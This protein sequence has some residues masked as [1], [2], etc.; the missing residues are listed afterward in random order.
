[1]DQDSS[2][3]TVDIE[4]QIQSCH[5]KLQELERHRA[6][7]KAA[8]AQARGEGPSSSTG[9]WHNPSG[10]P[11]NFQTPT[12]IP[13]EF[14]PLYEYYRRNVANKAELI[15]SKTADEWANRWIECW[16]KLGYTYKGLMSMV[17]KHDKSVAEKSADP[18]ELPKKLWELLNKNRSRLPRISSV[19]FIADRTVEHFMTE[20]KR[21]KSHQEDMEMYL[22]AKSEAQ[23]S[24][25]TTTP[26]P[27]KK[28][29][30]EETFIA[31]NKELYVF[32][33]NRIEAMVGAQDKQNALEVVINVVTVEA[34]LNGV[35]VLALYCCDDSYKQA[36]KP[37]KIYDLLELFLQSLDLRELQKFMSKEHLISMLIEYC[38]QSKFVTDKMFRTAQAFDAYNTALNSLPVTEPGPQFIQQLPSVISSQSSLLNPPPAPE[39]QSIPAQYLSDPAEI[40]TGDENEEKPRTPSPTLRVCDPRNFSFKHGYDPK[41]FEKVNHPFKKLSLVDFK[42]DNYLRVYVHIE[43]LGN[44]YRESDVI[45][46]GAYTVCGKKFFSAILPPQE[47][48]FE[49]LERLGYVTTGRHG[50][51]LRDEDIYYMHEKDKKVPHDTPMEG[52][53]EFGKF[54]KK[55]SHREGKDGV[56][57]M[58]LHSE[59]V[60]H[61]MKD[62]HG[63]FRRK[64]RPDRWFSSVVG[65]C[66]LEDFI[67]W[68]LLTK[69]EK[70]YRITVQQAYQMITGQDS[71]EYINEADF[72]AKLLCTIGERLWEQTELKTTVFNFE[73]DTDMQHFDDF[74][75]GLRRLADI[76]DVI[77][78]SLRRYPPGDS[79]MNGV[80]NLFP[81]SLHRREVFER[82]VPKD[83]IVANKY[84]EI[85]VSCGLTWTV[86]KKIEGDHDLNTLFSMIKQD[87]IDDE[88]S[89]G[90]TSLIESCIATTIDVLIRHRKTSKRPHTPESRQQKRVEDPLP[91]HKRLR[92]ESPQAVPSPPSRPPST[93]PS[94]SRPG[95]YTPTEY[96]RP[97]E[98]P[99]PDP[100]RQKLHQELSQELSKPKIQKDY[101]PL[102]DHLSDL[103]SQKPNMGSRNSQVLAEEMV[104][105]WQRISSFKELQERILTDQDSAV[106][107]AQ[108]KFH[109]SKN[110]SSNPASWC[111]FSLDFLIKTTMDFIKSLSKRAS[112]VRRPITDPQPKSGTQRKERKNEEK[113]LDAAELGFQNIRRTIP[114]DDLKI[115][116][117]VSDEFK[118]VL[119]SLETECDGIKG[120]YPMWKEM[121]SKLILLDF[122]KLLSRNNLTVS[123]LCSRLKK[124]DQPRRICSDLFGPTQRKSKGYQGTSDFDIYRQLFSRLADELLGKNTGKP[125]KTNPPKEHK[126][127]KTQK[128]KKNKSDAEESDDLSKDEN[129]VKMEPLTEE[130][131]KE[132]LDEFLSSKYEDYLKNRRCPK[133]E[134]LELHE[135]MSFSPMMKSGKNHAGHDRWRVVNDIIENMVS[136]KLNHQTILDK[137]KQLD[138]DTSV[139]Q[140]VENILNMDEPQLLPKSCTE[141]TGTILNCVT[142]FYEQ[143]R[144]KVRLSQK[145]LEM[146]CVRDENNGLHEL[147]EYIFRCFASE[148][149]FMI[150]QGEVVNLTLDQVN[151]DFLHSFAQDLTRFLININFTIYESVCHFNDGVLTNVLKFELKSRQNDIP[152]NFKSEALCRLC[153]D[154][155][156]SVVRRK[157]P[158][159]LPT[160]MTI[161]KIIKRKLYVFIKAE[162]IVEESEKIEFKLSVPVVVDEEIVDRKVKKNN[163][164]SSWHLTSKNQQLPIKESLASVPMYKPDEKDSLT[165]T[166]TDEDFGIKSETEATFGAEPFIDTVGSVVTTW[167]VRLPPN[168]ARVVKLALCGAPRIR[169]LAPLVL[170]SSEEFVKTGCKLMVKDAALVASNSVVVTIVNPN[171]TDAVKFKGRTRIGFCKVK[172]RSDVLMEVDPALYRLQFIKQ[173]FVMN[174]TEG[175]INDGS[176]IQFTNHFNTSFEK[177]TKVALKSVGESETQYSIDTLLFFMQHF[178]LKIHYTDYMQLAVAHG[179]DLVNK[180]HSRNIY[181]YLT[182][183]DSLRNELKVSTNEFV[184]HCV[185]VTDPELILQYKDYPLILQELTKY[186]D[187]IAK[188]TDT[189]QIRQS[190]EIAEAKR[191]LEKF[192]ASLQESN[193]RLENLQ[194]NG[195]RAGGRLRQQFVEVV[196][197]KL[198]AKCLQNPNLFGE[199]LIAKDEEAVEDMS[200][201]LIDRKQRDSL[202]QFS[203]MVQGQELI[204]KILQRAKDQD[205][206]EIY[207]D[208]KEALEELRRAAKSDLHSRAT[209]KL[210]TSEPLFVHIGTSPKAVSY[211]IATSID[212]KVLKCGSRFFNGVEFDNYSFIGWKPALQW[213][214][215]ENLDLFIQHSVTFYLD[216]TGG[217]DF[218]RCNVVGDDMYVQNLDKI[219]C[220]IR[221]SDR[222]NPATCLTF[223]ESQPPPFLAKHHLLEILVIVMAN[224]CKGIQTR[225][226]TLRAKKRKK[227]TQ[228]PDQIG[229][230]FSAT[231]SSSQDQEVDLQDPSSYEEKMWVN[232]GW[233]AMYKPLRDFCSRGIEGLPQETVDCL[234]KNLLEANILYRDLKKTVS[235]LEKSSDKI[236]DLKSYFKARG[237]RDADSHLNHDFM[238]LV[239]A[240]FSN[241]V[242][243]RFTF[244][245]EGDIECQTVEDSD[246]ESEVE[247][248]SEHQNSPKMSRPQTPEET[249]WFMSCLI[250][251]ETNKRTETKNSDKWKSEAELVT[252]KQQF[253]PLKRHYA[254][255]L[256]HSNPTNATDVD[257]VDCWVIADVTISNL[258]RLYN[259]NI[260]HGKKAILSKFVDLL[261][262][263][264]SVK[265]VRRNVLALWTYEYFSGKSEGIQRKSTFNDF[266]RQSVLQTQVRNYHSFVKLE[267]FYTDVCRHHMKMDNET[268]E[269]NASEWIRMWCL[270]GFSFEDLSFLCNA[271]ARLNNCLGEF[272]GKF[273]AMMEEVSCLFPEKFNSI[274][275]A[276][277]T[278]LYFRCKV[279]LMDLKENMSQGEL[280]K[281]W[282]KFKKLNPDL[283][284]IAETF[285]KSGVSV[286]LVAKAL[287]QQLSSTHGMP[288]SVVKIS[289][290]H[291]LMALTKAKSSEGDFFQFKKLFVQC[292]LLNQD[293]TEGRDVEDGEV[294]DSESDNE[295]NE[296]KDENFGFDGTDVDVNLTSDLPATKRVNLVDILSQIGPTNNK[297]YTVEDDHLVVGETWIPLRAETCFKNTG[298]ED[299]STYALNTILLF[300][301]NLSKPHSTYVKVVGAS[302]PETTPLHRNDRVNVKLFFEENYLDFIDPGFE[303]E[304]LTVSKSQSLSI[305]RKKFV[306]AT[307]SRNWVIEGAS[308]PLKSDYEEF[309]PLFEKYYSRAYNVGMKIQKNW[310]T[311]SQ[312]AAQQLVDCWRVSGVSWKDISGPLKLVVISKRSSRQRRSKAFYKTYNFLLDQLIEH[313]V[314]LPPNLILHEFAKSTVFFGEDILKENSKGEQPELVDLM[315]SCSDDD[316]NTAKSS[317]ESSGSMEDLDMADLEKERQELMARLSDSSSEENDEDNVTSTTNREN[318]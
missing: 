297:P 20:I 103:L 210:E 193:L 263:F 81:N 247:T 276:K 107:K 278:V 24:S 266:R 126:Q 288:N 59:S 151:F 187:N 255:M 219:D 60:M 191:R 42:M 268:S 153:A 227:T 41:L 308:N 61:L 190:I 313:T 226:R 175:I 171:S 152:E 200:M 90:I 293:K 306:E 312:L 111:G 272:V 14:K 102:C 211:L 88:M 76:A 277:I 245:L 172:N 141:F 32:M 53:E 33:E 15:K 49:C 30:P 305:L 248:L 241:K 236:Q 7:N 225:E 257:M 198:V 155:I 120:D 256:D 212:R 63:Q 122:L 253:L 3:V 5:A 170:W 281:G 269:K 70:M 244:K 36:G 243:T 292:A 108:L 271:A 64:R 135:Y 280:S 133:E 25:T 6:R 270:V 134:W 66:V 75:R 140:Y 136:M 13:E 294:S 284:E 265:G 224:L 181:L 237:V 230:D 274:L 205:E 80:F 115:W 73:F 173:Y 110:Y 74:F 132:S 215:K 311:V 45:Q 162:L 16:K 233:L 95:S 251:L 89:P 130:Q 246:D 231:C 163:G 235:E 182:G 195:F 99:Y 139:R 157:T 310:M 46:I 44:G 125:R 62:L 129:V 166:S 156:E 147:Y 267:A 118:Q 52:L 203:Q 84:C 222:G 85:L 77:P 250:D 154:W 92:N 149:E 11:S 202:L 112:S 142:G 23:V 185:D 196:T 291:A 179:K 69:C 315:S 19:S 229:P 208:E 51:K 113:Q 254:R 56:I 38:M 71:S 188:I 209:C 96:T 150:D 57:L 145:A 180:A 178:N 31:V 101:F 43:A 228:L 199:C 300:M 221:K 121:D 138:E 216:E 232:F 223:R 314:A 50:R 283:D 9:S 17:Y 262:G 124:G 128:Q 12:P 91:P 189:I 167:D 87:V 40:K 105:A 302:H 183:R 93:Q 303:V 296:W 148:L 37:S 68:N 86:L 159:S 299:H 98:P 275:V 72:K 234:I 290:Q 285:V 186:K 165:I 65:F 217:M 114:Q 174:G 286:Q 127:N 316:G 301:E 117:K 22:E 213:V 218:E 48:I 220:T 168:K 295:E 29:S 35:S 78:E 137:V 158:D 8:V 26:A 119:E 287:S 143:S 169:R 39:R 307:K 214:V 304:A 83:V 144:N 116:K 79:A 258:E 317:P 164:L 261:D 161:R 194:L 123:S 18:S 318:T 273:A 67:R 204:V 1:M 289:M 4:A 197:Q 298:G 206:L 100:K 131:V 184:Q 279:T 160:S 240:H 260:S 176:Q 58:F 2:E 28:L 47:C 239:I 146:E 201:K 242:Q 109:L 252:R 309:S 34:E 104:N 94:R 282:R 192:L 55:H 207:S 106:I 249:D 54:L 259:E 82:F 264:E 177:S 27:P 238:Q 10:N 21:L 97:P